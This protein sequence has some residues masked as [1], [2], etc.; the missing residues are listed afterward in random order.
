[1]YI[2]ISYI[3]IYED[4]Y[5][6]GLYTHRHTHTHTHT[7]LKSS[8]IFPDGSVVK[9]LPAVPETQQSRVQS[10]VQEDPLEEEMATHRSIL[11]WTIPWIEEAG[12][13]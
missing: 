9:N 13:L 10:L 2:S 3:Y 4:I 8:Y 5:E 6:S 11:A 7:Y 1:M 12:G